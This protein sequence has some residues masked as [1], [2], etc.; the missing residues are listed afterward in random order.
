[1]RV[2][3]VATN[4]M[5]SPFPVYP[6]GVDYVATALA[7]DHE[8]RVV[9]L[10]FSETDEPLVQALTAFKPQV[11][12][13]S[14]RN[15][16]NAEG[17]NAHSFVGDIARIVR[18]IREHAQA[19]VVLGGGGFS[20]FPDAFINHVGADY[21]IVGEGERVHDLVAAIEKGADT[22]LL[23][24][25]V[26]PH[27]TPVRPSPWPGPYV[28]DMYS[29][30]TVESYVRWGG[31]LNLQ[32]KRGCPFQCTY[33]T[34]PT[35]EGRRLRLFDPAL[36]AEEWASVVAAGAKFVSLTDAVFN[37]HPRHNM[38]VAEALKRRGVS[39]PWIAF[40][41]PLRPPDGYY[42]RLREAGLTH[43]EF[44]TEALCDSMLRG[45]R[46]PFTAEHALAAHRAARAAGLYVAHYIM[47]GGPGETLQTA[48]ATL[49]ACE[50]L[51]HAAL[52]FFCGVR[53]YP[54]TPL[55]Q[56][57]LREGQIKAD[58]ALLEP[59]FYQTREVPPEKLEELVRAQAAGRR[60]WI[61]GSGDAEMASIVERMHKRGR[62]GP[63]WE[64]IIP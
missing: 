48:Q 40:F 32:T 28:R 7:G 63:L 10:N 55:H 13:V 31:M 53:I 46:K 64:R 44:G 47:L 18:I 5:K 49:Q 39:V 20:I 15:V 45:Y 25:V 29:R 38:L 52:F 17:Q 16:D 35:I 26:H 2:L 59:R 61:I 34:Y 1:V 36:V 6:L 51:D 9:D 56:I 12:G 3:L 11:V 24:G 14:I 19:R 54:S 37:S 42:A 27:E 50:K 8:V 57:A 60:H 62:V 4:R 33:C 43:V 41:A 30:T 22:R 58:E 23:P 21:G